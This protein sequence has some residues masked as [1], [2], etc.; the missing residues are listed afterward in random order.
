MSKHT[1]ESRFRILEAM[2]YKMTTE[3][4][5]GRYWTE[6]EWYSPAGED[7]L[8]LIWHDNTAESFVKSFREYADDFDADEHAAEW[9]EIRGTRGVPDSIRTLLDD[10]EEIKDRLLRTAYIL[11]QKGDC[12][13]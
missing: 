2:G 5:D 7:C 3:E 1:L 4:Q 12:G 11:E 10:A 9:I 6:L 8:F 13:D